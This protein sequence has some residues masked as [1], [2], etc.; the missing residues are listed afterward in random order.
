MVDTQDAIY[1]DGRP[2]MKANAGVAANLVRAKFME[3]M[4]QAVTD[5]YAKS[6]FRIRGITED[7]ACHPIFPEAKV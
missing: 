3:T 1:I 4:Q 2:K 6:F 5:S 7:P